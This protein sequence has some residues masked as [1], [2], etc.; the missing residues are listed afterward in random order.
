MSTHLSLVE[1]RALL[2]AAGIGALAAMSKAGGGP[3]NPPGGAVAPTGR[4]LDEVYNKIA[5]PPAVG[6]YDGRIPIAGGTTPVTISAPGTYVLTG[7]LSVNALAPA[8]TISA[9][10]VSVDL[11][12]QVVGNNFNNLG[13]FVNEFSRNIVVRNGQFS[14]CLYGVFVPD[15]SWGVLLEDMLF[16]TPKRAGI[17][18][19]GKS[20]RIRRCTVADLGGGFAPDGLPYT[21]INCTGNMTTIE[22]CVVSKFNSNGFPIDP[23]QVHGIKVSGIANVVERCTVLNETGLGGNGISMSGSGT[24]RNNCVV[25]LTTKYNTAGMLDG[26]GN[27]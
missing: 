25:N 27:V 16:Y 3:L 21:G 4:T 26:G 8:L 11:N 24:Y 6:G 20:V 2:G 22:E 9:G 17:V 14:G 7:P 1:R 5:T 15:T 19:G 18:T 13:V 12:G 23:S 10:N